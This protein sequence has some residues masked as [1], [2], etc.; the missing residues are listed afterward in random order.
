MRGELQNSHNA[1]VDEL[2]MDAN[3]AFEAIK[4]I[5]QSSTD[6]ADIKAMRSRAREL[7]DQF[8]MNKAGKAGEA[9]VLRRSIAGAFATGRMSIIETAIFREAQQHLAAETP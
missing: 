6:P 7:I 2:S 1:S 5:A 8:R 4:K 9:K 3:Q